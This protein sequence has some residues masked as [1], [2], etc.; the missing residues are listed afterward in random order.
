VNNISGGYK[1]WPPFRQ[2]VAPKIQN[3]A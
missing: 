2:K 3:V 1:F